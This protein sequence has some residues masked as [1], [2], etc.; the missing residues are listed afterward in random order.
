MESLFRYQA[1]P[2]TCGY[3]PDRRWSLEY[4]MVSAIS[5]EEYQ[6]RMA[7]GWRRFGAMMFRPQ[8][9]ECQAC[10]TLRVDVGRFRPNR[11]QRR[12]QKTNE[13]R[14]ELRVGSPAVS[15][16]KLGLYDRFHAFQSDTK[17][18]PIHPA[19]DAASYRESFVHNPRFTEEWCYFDGDRLVG[20]GYVDRLPAALS[21]IYFY[22][23][24]DERALSLGTWNVL[25]VLAAARRSGLPHVYLGYFVP[26]C[27]SLA[28]K[29]NY[30]PNQTLQADGSWR[31]FLSAERE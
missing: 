15:R 8:C 19:K 17:S 29:A 4:E 1:P 6:E 2:S 16:T 21:A 14:L 12:S 23:D 20:V 31:D 3:L 13:G 22:Y 5:A 28:Y 10:R 30:R 24:P 26:D 7:H 27:R 18:W 9:P 25:C 11:S